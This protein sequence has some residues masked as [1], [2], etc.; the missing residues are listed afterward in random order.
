MQY[1]KPV[2]TVADSIQRLKNRG[3]MIA[4][5]QDA[6]RFLRAIGY[7]RFRGYALPFMEDAP[8]GFAHGN[9]QFRAGTTFSDVQGLYEFDRALRS[10]VMEQIDRI[11]VAVRTAI[12]QELNG[13]FGTHWYLDF[14]KKIFKD[15][16]DQAKWFGEVAREVDRSKNQPFIV[17]YQN[18]YT[19][20]R[21]PPSWAVAEC[22]S[23]GKWS[24]LYKQLAHGKS[25]IAGG[26]ALSAPILESWLH[27]LNVLRNACA[28]HGRI[29]NRVLPFTPQAHPHFSSHF[30]NP[31]RFY[32]R[33]A[34]IRVMTN[35]IDGNQNFSDGLKN[36]F[37]AH[38]TVNPSAMGFPPDWES[39]PLWI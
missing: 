27:S 32:S 22:L 36:L 24:T 7:F 28:H 16:A 9:R 38:P 30:A 17:H 18:K 21:L 5:D 29:W 20:P 10:L 39:D 35:V 33:A 2:L 3:L 15:A 31:S 1:L 37:A 8:V 19:N 34:A 4:N 12:L 26:F 6:E 13:T 25:A 23:F 14:S 11:E